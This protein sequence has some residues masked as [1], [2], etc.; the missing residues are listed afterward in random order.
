MAHRGKR[1]RDARK[2]SRETAVRPLGEALDFVKSHATAGVDETVEI[3][4]N[5]GIDARKSDQ[6]VRGTCRLPA[7]TGKTVRVAVFARGEK[8]EEAVASG[9]EVVGAEEL[10]E[11]VKKGEINFDRC[12]ATPDMM[13]LVGRVARILG[14]RGLMPNPKVGTVTQDVAEAVRNAKQGEIP[15]RAER[16]GIVHAGVGRA[17]FETAALER[18]VR[19]FVGAV[20]RAR[21]AAAKGTYLRRVSLSSSMGPGVRVEI[22]TLSE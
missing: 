19:A 21:P 4:I 8:A 3:A 6:S 12:V 7:G 2:A 15:F 5:L 18:N 13:R 11:A 10:V 17:S 16:G 22:A 9:A 20:A 1:V 14:P